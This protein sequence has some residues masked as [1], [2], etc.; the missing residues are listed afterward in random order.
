MNWVSR[1]RD[2]V[3]NLERREGFGDETSLYNSRVRKY[4]PHSILTMD[5]GGNLPHSWQRHGYASLLD[6][7]TTERLSGDA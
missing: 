2:F 5:P 1:L 3:L 4:A 6:P 7:G